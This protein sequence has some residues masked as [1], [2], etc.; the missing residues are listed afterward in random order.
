MENN[1]KN[2]H[3]NDSFTIWENEKY[4]YFIQ[5]KDKEIEPKAYD[6]AAEAIEV[7]WIR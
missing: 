6:V 5:M 2:Y 1:M 4:E 3:T 7:G